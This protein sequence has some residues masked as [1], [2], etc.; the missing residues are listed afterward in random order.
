LP[1]HSLKKVEYRD[2]LMTIGPTSKVRRAF[3]HY[4]RCVMHVAGSSLWLTARSETQL[5]ETAQQCKAMGAEDVVVV[6]VRVR[7]L[8]L[9][10]SICC[11]RCA[12]KVDLLQ[13][14]SSG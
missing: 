14:G 10:A 2:A 9:I 7:A 5:E 8:L 12:H 4:F 1:W 11:G 3:C 13:S 6:Q